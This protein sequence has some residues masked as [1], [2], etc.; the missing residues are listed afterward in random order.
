MISKRTFQILTVIVVVII[1]GLGILD[2]ISDNPFYSLSEDRS[3]SEFFEAFL[4]LT[5]AV[6]GFYIGR[7][8]HSKFFYSL[9]LIFT[10]MTADNLLLIHET[11]GEW[12]GRTGLIS[13]VAGYLGAPSQ[14]LGE[15]IYFFIV[16]AIIVF[17]LLKTAKGLHNDQYSLVLGVIFGGE[18]FFL[19]AVVFDFFHMIER[20]QFQAAFFIEDF[21]ELVFLGF[22]LLWFFL[23][24]SEYQN[25]IQKNKV[26]QFF[27]KCN[28]WLVRQ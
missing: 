27:L 2:R 22:I 25:A 14:S 21:M 3:L 15:V 26:V 8:E 17:V 6:F 19:F 12:L 24:H 10:Y 7:K 16:I 28:K 4:L 5:A 18:L 1:V 23:M 9:G 20:F 11:I 13:S